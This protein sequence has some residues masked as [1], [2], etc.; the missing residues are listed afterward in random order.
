MVL[1][2]DIPTKEIER[3][4]KVIEDTWDYKLDNIDHI[5]IQL[6]PIPNSKGYTLR[7]RFTDK[8]KQLEVEVE[9]IK[10]GLELMPDDYI[11]TLHPDLGYVVTQSIFGLKPI[12]A[13]PNQPPYTKKDPPKIA[14]IDDI[15]KL[16]IPDPYSDGLMPE[17]LERIKYLMEETDYQFPCSLLD[18]GG[19]MDMAYELMGT[20]L[21]FTAMYDAPDALQYLVNF[22]ADV[23]I[24]LRDACIKAAGGIKNVTCVEWDE[25]WFPKKGY[26]SND[27]AAMY[28]PEFFKKFAIP[29]DNK[30][31][32]KYG[33]GL[34][35]NCGPH[36]SVD[37]YLR[38]NPRIYGLTC[39][40]WD[41]DDKTLKRIKTL[42]DHKAI[43]YVELR[44]TESIDKT[45][46]EYKRVVDALVPNVIA[47]PWM[48]VGP[49][50]SLYPIP[51]YIDVR[52]DTPI[53][54]NKLLKICKEYAKKMRKG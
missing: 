47:I 4:K 12:Y 33:G 23:S 13:D 34:I 21:F 54:Y 22:L 49:S 27:L 52:R 20:N 11:P 31:Y 41:L 30:I 43:L 25:K 14:K 53:L 7:E 29:A 51:P 32:K 9:K 26:V 1:D 15:Y 35:H 40:A 18:V 17:G 3:R 19:P 6:I 36:P 46:E 10:A 42:F 2:F 24:T 48:W 16:K 5:P 38:D 39:T 44:I 37:F 50:T 8:K 45:V 28:S